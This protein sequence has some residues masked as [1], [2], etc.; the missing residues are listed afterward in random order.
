MEIHPIP[1]PGSGLY[2]EFIRSKHLSVGIY[3]LGIGAADLQQLHSEDE[4]YYIRAGRAR[5]TSGDESVEVEPGLC[6]F[7]PAQEQRRFHDITEPLEVLVVFGP[8]EGSRRRV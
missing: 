5:F 1:S 7:V 3:R 2:Q 4:V 8:A 6:L